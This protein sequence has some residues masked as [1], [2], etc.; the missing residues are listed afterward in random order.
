MVA[1]TDRKELLKSALAA[2]DEMQARLDAAEQAKR[3]PIAI[4]GMSC[5]FPGGANSPERYWQ[6]LRA[7]V[8]L[9]GP[10]PAGRWPAASYEQLDIDPARPI[11]AWRGGF[12]DQIDAFDAQLFGI[13]PREMATMDPQ[14]RLV[15]EVAWEALERAGIAPD[16]L[17]GSLTGVFMGVTTSDYG[18]LTRSVA[19][20]EL[21]VYVATGSALNVVAG[22]LAYTLGLQGPCMAVDTACSS[23]LV[24]IHLACQ[25]LR[26]QESDIAITGGVNALIAPEAFLVFNKWGMMAS[27][28]RCKTF[29]VR[30]DGFV[31]AEGCGVLVLKRLADATAAGDQVLGLIRGSAVNQD[32]RSTG[33]TAPNGLAQQQVI[34]AALANAGVQP[35]DISYVE[36][37]GTGTSLGDPIE[38]EAIGAALRAGRTADRPLLM[39]S[40]KTNIG[41]AESAAGVA[42]VIKTVL[43]MQHG[44]LPPHLHLTRRSPTI[45]WPD[46]PIEIPTQPVAWEGYA[47]QRLAGVSAFGFSGTNAHVILE[48]APPP[49]PPAQ[50][51]VERSCHLITLSARSDEAL[52]AAAGQ[53][54]DFLADQPADELA[55]AAY[56]ANNGRARL[57]QRLAA[58]AATVEDA[59]AKLR[60]FASGEA[61]AGVSASGAR[62]ERQRVVFMFTGQGAQYVGMGRLLYDT[63][64][65]FRAA[66]DAC[67]S[68]LQRHLP[69]G[70]LPALYGED[71]GSRLHHTAYTQPALF[72]L[73]YALAQLWMSWGIQPHAVVGHSVGEFTAA[74]IAGVFSLEDGLN[75]I[76]ER[77]R[78]MG[79]LPAGGAMVA[80]MADEPAVAEVIQA[81][82]GAVVIATLNGPQNTVISGA[83][84]AAAAAAAALNAQGIKTQRLNVSHAFHS[85]L[86]APMLPEFERALAGVSFSRPRLPL[87]ANASG[88]LAGDELAGPAYWL[89]QA[90]GVVRFA[91]DIRALHEAGYRT[92]LELG[93]G[94]TLLS[95]GQRVVDDGVWLPS[96]REKRDDWSVL[97]GSLGKL[98]TLGAEVDWEGFD[99]DYQRR[100]VT[101]PTYAFQRQ[102]YWVETA[103]ARRS[104]A[105][106]ARSGGHPLLGQALYSPL[107][108]EIVYSQTIGALSPRLLTDHRIYA[109]AVFPGTGYLELALAAGAALG[110]GR[111]VLRDV[112]IQ[113]PLL[114]AADDSYLLQT[115]ISP[116]TPARCQFQI[117]SAEPGDSAAAAP[118]QWTRHASGYIE[119]AAAALDAADTPLLAALRA[120]CTE[121]VSVTDYYARLSALGLNY[122]DSFRSIRALWFDPGTGSVLGHIRLAEHLAAEAE[123]YYLHAGM[124]DSCFHLLGI[125]LRGEGA[126]DS[127]FFLPMGLH[128]LTFYQ[129]G[130]AAFWAAAALRPAADPQADTRLGDVYLYAE[131]GAPIAVLNGLA[132]RRANQR[133]LNQFAQTDFSDWLYTAGWTQQPLPAQ[134]PQPAGNWLILADEGG[135]GERLAAQLAEAGTPSTLVYARDVDTAD[136]RG[137]AGWLEAHSAAFTR[138]IHLWALD[139]AAE[140]VAGGLQLGLRS[141]LYLLQAVAQQGL[142]ARVWLVT[143]GAQ[144]FQQGAASAAAQAPLWGLGRVIAHEH[145]ELWG[146]LVDIDAVTPAKLLLDALVA[147]DGEDQLLLRFGERYAGRLERMRGQPAGDS[148]AVELA[149]GAK[150]E[151]DSLTLVPAARR[152][153]APGA[154][155]VRVLA[156]GLNFRDVLNTLG[157]YPGA[158]A[159]LGTECA[160]VVVGVGDGVTEFAPGDRV[161]ALHAGSFSSYVTVERR[162]AFH[163]PD[164][165]TFA[166]AAA[167]PSIFLTAYYGLHEL[168]GIKAGDR[169]LIHA[170]AGGVGLA[171]VQ[172]AQRAGAEV[173]A[174]VGSEAKREYLRSIGVRHIMSSRTLDFAEEIMAAT[175]GA[176]VDIVLNALADDFIPASFSVLAAGGCFLEIGKRAVWTQEQAS[177]R[178]PGRVYHAYDLAELLADRQ[179]YIP[180]LLRRLLDAFAAGDLHTPPIQT[181]PIESVV[182]AFRYMARARHIGKLVVT[183]EPQP[184]FAGFRAD[185][186]YL[187]TG[188]LGGLGLTTAAW[189]VEQ[190]ARS[191]VL[192][193]RHAP[194]EAA[195]ATI[196]GLEA[197]G[198]RVH[199]AQVDVS[200][201]AQ[202]AQLIDHIAR[203]LPPLRGVIHAAGVVDDGLLGQQ[204]WSRFERVLAPKAV[205][206]WNLHQATQHIPLDLFV[207]FSSGA[208]VFGPPGQGSYAAANAFLDG[209]AL[210]R[211]AHGLAA[212]SVNWGAW[213]GVGMA[214]AMPADQRRRL[215]N[216]GVRL[217]APEQGVQALGQLIGWPAAQVIVSPM[218]W[219]AWRRSAGGVDVPPFFAAVLSRDAA[220]GAAAGDGAPAQPQPKA[221]IRQTLLASP[222]PQQAALLLDYLHRQIAGILGFPQA[223]LDTAA[224][225][226]TVGTD[227]LMAVEIKNH[228]EGYL[229][230]S[231]SVV[232]LLQGPSIQELSEYILQ[233]LLALKQPPEGEQSALQTVNAEDG[234]EEGEL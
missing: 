110:P 179:D 112:E 81:L 118:H 223:S 130:G 54:A 126:G 121:E 202:T 182:D 152:P 111:V 51:A 226:A 24:A 73:E 188:G 94:T 2:L 29:D 195:A 107:H 193:G 149:L 158:A 209:L 11:S 32:G 201:A 62:V 104:V 48:A 10:V 13:T 163:L 46:F 119:L 116:I 225:L 95:M 214:A 125:A 18:A 191:V 72:A 56:T 34:R 17:S 45:P 196:A 190:G 153:P 28:G 211:Q 171:A 57:S 221:S 120:G 181:F 185:G 41:H 166:Q 85:P 25:S 15:L 234:W 161:L 187:I 108:P 96:L 155:E 75:L 206:A 139:V 144:A 117:F 131:D 103:P 156:T 90:R 83:E 219:G 65:T 42:G 27:D 52:R 159:V 38:V 142:R 205:G 204:D 150:G 40:V 194:T 55:N 9:V 199:V 165:L 60:A 109:A 129:K 192:V 102:R 31:R 127:T 213:S 198:A 145:A 77:G 146:G 160:G 113:Q 87:A 5:R 189:M 208:A 101:L 74:C 12:L 128:S 176:G 61:A 26:N 8:D 183:Q 154:I 212:Q 174:T 147:D 105:G 49:P 230:V 157:M 7:G 80:A 1:E 71:A 30:A 70:L 37:H 50:N 210:Y 170:A 63:Q 114:L 97:L 19:P 133:V 47:G 79:A 167:I 23:S 197:A 93:P 91:D 82:G 99:R 200:D 217:I 14:Q 140:D 168:A 229:G 123:D 172:L 67:D 39:G 231:V 78:L 173:F 4:I 162:L 175:A 20:D 148:Q 43:A 66:L 224:P 177:E 100:R 98:Y 220:G 115:I 84:D 151:L 207:L 64:P 124:L 35:Q 180:D 233:Q 16:R 203:S 89:R 53:M 216:Q 21:D 86:M 228:V 169:V 134:I 76:A 122:G 215:Q 33:L 106:A 141:A 218:D 227:S 137:L 222:P 6:L 3:E 68:I 164:N 36:A 184:A 186:T 232:Q 135:M 59:S 92:F 136:P 138:V 44:E 22:R 132:L 143:R 88:A 69:G 58:A 178:Y